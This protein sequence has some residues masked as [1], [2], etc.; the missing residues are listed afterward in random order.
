MDLESE[1]E[2]D[3]EEEQKPKYSTILSEE[4][5]EDDDGPESYER[6][7]LQDNFEDPDPSPEIQGWDPREAHDFFRIA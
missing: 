5:Y 4:E 3:F 7:P 6:S 1:E 2:S